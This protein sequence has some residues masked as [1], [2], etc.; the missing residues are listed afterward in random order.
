MS[1][2]VKY[3]D[4]MKRSTEYAQR[5]NRLS[6]RIFG[7]VVRQTNSKS[8]K[9]VKLFSAE[10]INKRKDLYPYYP[11]HIETGQ[12]M[13]NLRYYGL[14]RDEHADFQDE[15]ERLRVLRGKGKRERK[16]RKTEK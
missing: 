10:P 12:L 11:R 2:Y 1:K 16:P 6:N 15:M 3:S 9:V 8:M 14:F 13:L 5:M 7:E 4:L